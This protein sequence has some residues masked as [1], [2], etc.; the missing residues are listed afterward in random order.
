MPLQEIP[1][2]VF[3]RICWV[4]WFLI[5]FCLPPVTSSCALIRAISYFVT[6]FLFRNK[7]LTPI[8]QDFTWPRSETSSTSTST[9]TTLASK[10]R[11]RIWIVRSRLISTCSWILTRLSGVS[12]QLDSFHQVSQTFHC[13][14]QL[15][16]LLCC[17]TINSNSTYFRLTLAMGR[18]AIFICRLYR[19]AFCLYFSSNI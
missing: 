11:C 10:W 16:N 12:I 9:S 18:F 19:H 8:A 15:A 4:V 6:S 5:H 3:L 7:I 2:T 1:S 13:T 17:C 14:L